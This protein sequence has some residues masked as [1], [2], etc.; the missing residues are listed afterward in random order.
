MW[1]A[2]YRPLTSPWGRNGRYIH[3]NATFLTLSLRQLRLNRPPSCFIAASS[4]T[5]RCIPKNAKVPKRSEG[6]E[7]KGEKQ[8]MP[9]QILGLEVLKWL[10]FS[11]T[12]LRGLQK[13]HWQ[14][15]QSSGWT[16]AGMSDDPVHFQLRQ[17]PSYLRRWAAARVEFILGFALC[18]PF[19]RSPFIVKPCALKEML[20]FR[21]E[22]HRPRE[23]ETL[24]SG[25]QNLGP[26]TERVPRNWPKKREKG[27]EIEV[28]SQR[29]YVVHVHRQTPNI[30]NTVYTYD[31]RPTVCNHAWIQT[32]ETNTLTVHV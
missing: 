21:E 18:D 22:D 12:V 5:L 32:I 29:L 16:L 2:A 28:T 4:I 20:G 7:T 30:N 8:H 9:Y 31:H 15:C 1:H 17:K 11:A 6:L 27:R 23:H 24:G 3:I 26:P 10:V 14:I 13:T 25:L 19:V